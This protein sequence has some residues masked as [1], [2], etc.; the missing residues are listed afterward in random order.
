MK[1]SCEVTEARILNIIDMAVGFTAMLRVFQKGSAPTV[2]TMLRRALGR[3]GAVRTRRQFEGVHQRFCRAFA[4]KVRV[5][6]TGTNASYGHGAK[7]LDVALKVCVHYCSLPS[8]LTARRIRPLLH[9]GIDTP[10]MKHLSL[11]HSLRLAASSIARL[12]AAEY[13]LLQAAADQE[14]AQTFGSRT[15]RVDL[16]DVL[17][18]RLNRD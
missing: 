3:L 15:T 14:I 5:A 7:V 11:Q 10:I 13:G 6:K 18:R 8:P 4:R 17:W 9:L 2:K 1:H 12:G 16:D